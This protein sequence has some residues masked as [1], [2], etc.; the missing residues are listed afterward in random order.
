MAVANAFLKPGPATGGMAQEF[1]RRYRGDVPVEYLYSAL[2]PILGGTKRVM[3]FQEQ[4]MRVARE[5]AGLSWAQAN[6]I[7]KGMSKFR[8]DELLQLRRTFIEGCQSDKGTG[9]SVSQAKIL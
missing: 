9:L 8:R 6:Q 4:V 3:L 2:E 5:I 7:R 1:V